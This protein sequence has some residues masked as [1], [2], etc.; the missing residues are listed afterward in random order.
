MG[1][2]RAMKQEVRSLKPKM[3]SLRDRE[4][5]ACLTFQPYQPAPEL[6]TKLGKH[7]HPVAGRLHCRRLRGQRGCGARKAERGGSLPCPQGSAHP[8]PSL[9]PY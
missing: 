7:R 8:G 2:H 1:K 9:S 4:K 6:G 5:Q 3:L